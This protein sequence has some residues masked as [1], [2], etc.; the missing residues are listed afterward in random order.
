[1]T[2]IAMLAGLLTAP[3]PWI[4]E[5]D[6]RVARIRTALERNRW[7]EAESEARDL[8]STVSAG[9]ATWSEL[10]ENTR[11]RQL[12]ADLVTHVRDLAGVVEARAQ[13]AAV[14]QA[15]ICDSLLQEL[16]AARGDDRP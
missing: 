15:G 16:A 13:D 12:L 8:R 2:T 9:A 4:E 14:Y 11:Q 7:A 6:S 1:M 10:L 5:L 3:P